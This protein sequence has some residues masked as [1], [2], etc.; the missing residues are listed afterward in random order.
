MLR[1]AKP[2]RE[3]EPGGERRRFWPELRAANLSAI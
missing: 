3:A 2:A 1:D